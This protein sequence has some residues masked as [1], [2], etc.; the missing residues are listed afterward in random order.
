M[1]VNLSYGLYAFRMFSESMDTRYKD[2]CDGSITDTYTGLMWQ[3]K[4]SYPE[5]GRYLD[6]LEAKEFIAG[7]NRNKL[8][9]Y[10]D[11]RLPNRLEIQSLYE[12]NRSFE[13]RGRTYKLHMDPVFE[14]SYGSCYWTNHRRLSAALGFEFDNGEIHWYP[15]ASLS[16]SARGVRLNMNSFQL[17]GAYN[18]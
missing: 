4:Y 2:H 10:S 8:A 16:G 1:V 3:E 17:L 18:K 9:G 7:L 6:W 15:A 11:W 13:S 14:F 12:M 5:N